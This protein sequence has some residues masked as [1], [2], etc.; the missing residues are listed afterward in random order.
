MHYSYYSYHFRTF[1]L[2]SYTNLTLLLDIM[3]QVLILCLSFLTCFTLLKSNKYKSNKN[4]ISRIILFKINIFKVNITKFYSN[5]VHTIAKACNN[6]RVYIIKVYSSF[7]SILLIK[8]H[9][10]KNFNAGRQAS[11]ALS[12]FSWVLYL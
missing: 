1:N 6:I 7:S 11:I 8:S 9:S 4:N 2:L 12:H 10:R 3:L 5:K